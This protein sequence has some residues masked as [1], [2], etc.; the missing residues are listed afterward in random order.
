[1]FA[2]H[3]MLN[4]SPS[5]MASSAGNIHDFTE[6]VSGVQEIVRLMRANIETPNC[7]GCPGI[8]IGKAQLLFL[9]EEGFKISDIAMMHSCSRRTIERKL[10]KYS[11]F[12]T[13]VH[14][15]E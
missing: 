3:D 15:H 9:V 4:S 13:N 7:R 11:I 2:H 6:L 14:I 1:M 12:S 5:T 10:E 8:H